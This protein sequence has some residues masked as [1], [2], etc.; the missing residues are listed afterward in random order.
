MNKYI[1]LYCDNPSPPPSSPTDV[2]LCHFIW[3]IGNA[4]H[5]KNRMLKHV[6]H[7]LN[8][9]KNLLNHK[10]KIMNVNNYKIVNIIILLMII[11]IFVNY[12]V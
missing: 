8:N 6:L 9:Y 1:Y 11:K 7:I 2:I 4:L 3:P 12:A 10:I 5:K